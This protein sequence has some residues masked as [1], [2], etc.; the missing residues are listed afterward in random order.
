MWTRFNL[1]GRVLNLYQHCEAKNDLQALIFV[2]F[3][4]FSDFSNFE[5]GLHFLI[6][7]QNHICMR[8][9]IVA[10]TWTA[11]KVK[12]NL[13]LTVS[14]VFQSRPCLKSWVGMV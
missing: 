3:F 12:N 14:R 10:I 8:L 11:H 6:L 9:Y 2:L 4:F 7:T 1:P 13:W 5:D